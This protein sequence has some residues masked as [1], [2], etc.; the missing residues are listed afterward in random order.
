MT[1]T[2]V[3]PTLSEAERQQR[4]E[5]VNYGRASVRLEGFVLDETSEALF[6]RYV[7]G[8]LTRAELNAEVLRLAGVHG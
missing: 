6:A 3:R 2:E 5:A 1:A 4:R 7:A 8:E